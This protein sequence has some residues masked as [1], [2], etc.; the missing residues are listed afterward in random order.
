M[1]APAGTGPVLDEIVVGIDDCDHA[2]AALEF[3][4]GEA[5]VRG[6]RLT[7]LHVWTRPQAGQ[8]DGYHDWILSV[9][10]VNEGAAMLLSERVA[11]W[12]DKYPGVLVTES[13]VHGHPGRVLAPASRGAD[14][15]VVGGRRSG[16]APVPGLD[17]VSY[18]M[19]Q[20]AQCPVAVIPGGA[21]RVSVT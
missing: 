9:D 19:L 17:P 10:P 13:T 3:G 4:F 21:I 12:R 11:R 2:A 7:A 16:L 18:A 1:F 6:A 20:N 14:L 5:D 8:L 15:V